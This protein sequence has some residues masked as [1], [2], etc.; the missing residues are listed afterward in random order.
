MQMIVAYMPGILMQVV[1]ILVD[2]YT[3]NCVWVLAYSDHFLVEA[4][5]MFYSRHKHDI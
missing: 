5:R 2:A 3:D 4:S 1:L